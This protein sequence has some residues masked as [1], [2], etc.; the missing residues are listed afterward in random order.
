MGMISFKEWRSQIN[1]QG[2]LTPE[3]IQ[4]ITQVLNNPNSTLA[5]KATAILDAG[6]LNAALL[7]QRTA[8]KETSPTTVTPTTAPSTI[9]PG[10]PAVTPTA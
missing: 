8:R 7:A 1:E 3:Q 9:S 2:Q 5:Q 6:T 10:T 4:K